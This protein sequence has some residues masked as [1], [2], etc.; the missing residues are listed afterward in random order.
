MAPRVQ[1]AEQVSAGITLERDPQWRR[2]SRPGQTERL[3][4]AGHQAQ[5]VLQRAAD[6]LPA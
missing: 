1:L 6:R 4:V 3:N 2:P 5:L